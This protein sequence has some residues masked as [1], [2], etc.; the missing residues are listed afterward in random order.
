MVTFSTV[1]MDSL[2]G[3]GWF[4]DLSLTERFSLL[5][6]GVVVLTFVAGALLSWREEHRRAHPRSKPLSRA[7][8][9]EPRRPA[10]TYPG[11]P[12]VHN[13]RE[14]TALHANPSQAPSRTAA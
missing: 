4:K 1:L 13:N 3:A 5:I 9:R 6:A 10:R 2:H 11:R 8:V 7:A 12:L 14:T